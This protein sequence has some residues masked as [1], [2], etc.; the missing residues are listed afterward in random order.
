MI[1]NS[2]PAVSV[3]MPS[4]N[5]SNYIALAIESILKQTYKDFE[6]IIIDD[7]STDNTL[8]IIEKYAIKDNRI[9]V[10]KN[11]VNLNIAKSRNKGVNLSRGKYIMTM[12]ADDIAEQ[13]RIS[14]QFRFLQKHKDIGVCIGNMKIIDKDSKFLYKRFYPKTDDAIKASIY[15]FN[16]FPNP[17]IMARREVYDKVGEYDHKYVPIDD[18]D[19]WLR[20]GK[21][22]KFANVEKFV[23]KYR[24]IGDS[25]SHKNLK[26]TDKLTFQLRWKALVELKYKFTFFD[27]LYNCGHLFVFLFFSTKMEIRLFN[28]LRKSKIL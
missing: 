24:I 27:I 7:Y 26:K 21:F 2:I 19:F 8:G 9:I 12:D 13:S 25:N 20:A 6:F 16:P 4:Y 22:F 14:N 17:T 1:N 28:F 11:N 10:V 5:A 3:V 23:L 18:F 15:K